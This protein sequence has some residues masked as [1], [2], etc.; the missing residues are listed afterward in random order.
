MRTNFLYAE[1]PDIMD[2]FQ[3]STKQH[4]KV[5]YLKITTQ[6]TKAN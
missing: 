1:I 6:D 4:I 5:V 2:L 3:A